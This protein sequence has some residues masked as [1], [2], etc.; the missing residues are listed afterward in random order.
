MP[1]AALTVAMALDVS[2]EEYPS[3]VHPVALFG[4]LVESLDRP[5][6]HPRA[7]GVTVAVVLPLGVAGLVGAATALAAWYSPLLGALVAGLLLFATV[8]LRMLLSVGIDVID[9][10]TPSRAG[11]ADT[12]R[13]DAATQTADP[14]AVRALVGRETADLSP[15]QIRSAA[16]ESLAENL[17]DG[18]VAPLFAFVLGAQLSLPVAVGA[19]VWVKAV[20]TL[21]SMLGYHST[22][23]GWASARLDDLVMWLPARITAACLA[24]VGR[25]VR[26]LVRA[27]AWQ[28]ETASPNSGWPMATL[29]AVLDVRLEKPGAY[30]L[31]PD[32]DLPT[33]ADALRGVRLVGAGGAV[34]VGLS[35]AVLWL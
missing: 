1:V 13:D 29:A 12:A 21:D 19:A 23:H 22:P 9:S 10:T 35:G 2:I 7:A 26:S 4:R 3:R 25:S 6:T 30:V 16:V 32:R 31:N 11:T 28:S 15:A 5:W 34:A 24:L 33:V 20:N 17:S 14:E 8:S 27:R 18:F